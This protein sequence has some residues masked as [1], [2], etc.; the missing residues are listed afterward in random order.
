MSTIVQARKFILGSYHDLPNILVVSS[1]VLGA[2]IGYLP[3]VWV[4]L[5]L[6][7]NAAGITGLQALLG[8]LFPEW[9][10]VRQPTNGLACDVLGRARMSTMASGREAYTIVAPSHWLGATSFFS[11]FIIYN[12]AMLADR[13]PST[14]AKD[15]RYANRKAFSITTIAIAIMF[16]LFVLLRGFTGCETWL[17]AMLGVLAGTGMAVGFWNLLDV[18]GAG[19][20]PDVL[21]AINAMAPSS[22]AT[23]SPVVCAPMA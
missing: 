19:S 18:C 10:Q 12:S 22:T 20:V 5:G 14:S 9:N 17:G 11:A 13:V 1:L 21:Q 23:E 3:L 7:V 8:F 4:S 6:L 16:L 2:L 15:E